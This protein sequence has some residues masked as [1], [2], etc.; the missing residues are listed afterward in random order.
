MRAS[1]TVGLGDVGQ[2]AA[3]GEFS[4][5]GFGPLEN[6]THDLG[7]DLFVQLRDSE[8]FDLGLMLGVQVKTGPSYLSTPG[9]VDGEIGWWFFA[10]ARHANYWRSHLLRH[11]VVLV[12]VDE[13][14]RPLRMFWAPLTQETLT[15]T[16]NNFKVFVPE[17]NDLESTPAASLIELARERRREL[18]YAGQAWSYRGASL[19]FEDRARFSMMV[20]RLVAPHPNRRSSLEVIEWHEAAALALQ[21]DAEAWKRVADQATT[22][23]DVEAARAHAERTW[24]FAALVH[25]WAYGVPV[26][27]S[28]I[29]DLTADPALTTA[30]TLIRALLRFESDPHGAVNLLRYTDMQHVVPEDRAWHHLI[31]GR[32]LLEIS[33][34]DEAALVLRDAEE[35]LAQIPSDD[36]TVDYL[37]A[38]VLVAT[39]NFVDEDDFARLITAVDNPVNWWRSRDLAS[40]LETAI[41]DSYRREFSHGDSHLGGESEAHNQLSSIA[42]VAQISGAWD[43]WRNAEG[44]NARRAVLLSGSTYDN[45]LAQ[46]RRAGKE[47]ALGAAIRRLIDEGPTEVLRDFVEGVHPSV[48]TSSTVRCDLLAV[49]L[50]HW[51]LPADQAMLWVGVL[52][53]AITGTHSLPEPRNA[54]VKDDYLRTLT[55]LAD[56][57][58][59]TDRLAVARALLEGDYLQH[60]FTL[61]P[62]LHLASKLAIPES[63]RSDLAN[64]IT[65]ESIARERDRLLMALFSGSTA[66]NEV[67]SRLLAEGNLDGMNGYAYWSD[68]SPEQLEHVIR[69]AVQLQEQL[70]I[71][72]TAEGRSMTVAVRDPGE[73]MANAALHAGPDSDAWTK[74]VELMADE[75]LHP[76]Y[77]ESAAAELVARNR[78]IPDH[79]REG[80]LAATSRAIGQYELPDFSVG[81]LLGL[82]DRGSLSTLQLALSSGDDFQELLTQNLCDPATRSACL[83]LLGTRPGNELLLVSLMSDR[84]PQVR[85]A[86]GSSLAQ[87]LLN[88]PCTQPHFLA[89]LVKHLH[90]SGPGALWGVLGAIRKSGVAKGAIPKEL[91]KVLEDCGIPSVTK[92]LLEQA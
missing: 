28:Y 32:L 7:T 87:S 64:I 24:R 83:E 18:A 88:S 92:S 23:P 37:R 1:P 79:I 6:P 75:D 21:A 10:D 22:V 45:P 90:E 43:Q 62:A 61:D 80:L 11:V 55:R 70:R 66:S 84:D 60:P 34:W 13:D 52:V 63:C 16:G 86:A 26:D 44:L 19:A 9:S 54:V 74:L 15:S 51:M 12:E 71:E 78:Q 5:K 76:A 73:L 89:A 27:D 17:E 14:K 67:A 68:L 42:L 81:G 91:V 35:L 2:K 82:G 58:S 4:R 38:Q 29:D 50:L 31:L 40:A 8:G 49:R 3:F 39:F 41:E 48:V 36:L 20:P 33:A 30:A 59:E 77:K 65:D 47:R 46:L 56:V 57:L 69:A 85:L 53:G 25:D 72:R